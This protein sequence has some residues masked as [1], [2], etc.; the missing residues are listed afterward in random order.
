MYPRTSY[1]MTESDLQLLIEA[2]KPVPC[3]MI[4]G[5]TPP[6]QQG[7]ANRAWASLGKRM[8]FDYD[9]ARPIYGKGDRFFSA[10]P[11]ENEIQRANRIASE[12]EK[13]GLQR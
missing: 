9:T 6:S 8:G 13:R 5:T 2:G 7:N 11:S 3:M 10:V 4:G 1:E 12:E